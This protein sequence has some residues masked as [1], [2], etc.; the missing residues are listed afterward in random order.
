MDR[1]DD[2]YNEERLEEAIL[3]LAEWELTSMDYTS[4]Q[5]YYI[6]AKIEYY[7]NNP[8]GFQDMLQY[9]K[10]CTDPDTV[11]YWDVDKKNVQPI[12]TRQPTWIDEKFREIARRQDND[13]V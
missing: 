5:E 12:T 13:E 7:H 10:E 9:K 3:D 2:D 6:E 11:F 8:E 4:L 1:I